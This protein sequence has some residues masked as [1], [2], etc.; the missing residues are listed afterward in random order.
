V[1]LD[2]GLSK[3][4]HAGA[5]THEWHAK[6]S[7]RELL[8]LSLPWFALNFQ[9]AALLPVVIPAQILLFVAPGAAAIYSCGCYWSARWSIAVGGHTR[10]RPLH[11]WVVCGG[12][13][14]YGVRHGVPGVGARLRSS[15]PT[16][17]SLRI[18]GIDDLT[19]H[20]REP[21]CR[22]CATGEIQQWRPGC[23]RH[24]LGC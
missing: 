14:Q 24:C 20:R 15:A 17:S 19:R 5:K 2:I 1:S 4:A 23:S 6:L 12:G 7:H 22:I 9:F 11:C 18:H 13:C 3:G 21:G 8:G 10:D 16:W